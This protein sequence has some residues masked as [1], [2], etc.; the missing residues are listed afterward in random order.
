MINI[1]SP[2][3][4]EC[5]R[6]SG[7]ILRDCLLY[8]EERVKPGVSTK[9][10]DEFAYDFIKRHNSTPSFLGYGGFPGTICA[11]IDEVVVHG[12]PSERRLKEGEIIGVDCGLVYKGWQSD[13]ARTFLIGDVSE[14][15]RK[16]VQTT[17]ESFFEGVKQFKDGGHLGD[18]SHAIQVYCE[19]RGYGI[20]RSMTGHGIGKEMHE[21][22]GVPNYGRRGRGTHLVD[23]M[24]LC[25]EP[26][27]N[28]GGKAVYLARNGW[29]VH[30][31]DHS[32]A[33]HYELTVVVRKGCA[34]QLST[35]D[36]IEKDGKIN[37]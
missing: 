18:I 9:K 37:F 33:A 4:I 31:A 2:Q 26:M 20:V 6:K 17:R 3:E 29:A 32:K 28:A 8:L 19:D 21:N 27:V 14:E 25:I 36:F 24:A 10:L 23:G 11:S 16:L 30:T 13:A 1:K 7:A 35:Y 15:K 34:E 5:M 12:F 22:P